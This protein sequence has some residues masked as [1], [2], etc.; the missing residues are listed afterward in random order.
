MPLPVHE[1]SPTTALSIVTLGALLLL[2]AFEAATGRYRD[3]RK[4]VTDWQMFGLST[5][6]IVLLERPLLYYLTYRLVEALGPLPALPAVRAWAAEHL[7]LSVVA[8]IAIDELVHGYAHNFAHKPI[9]KHRLLA[10]LHAFYREAHRGHHLV[11]GPDGKGEVSVTQ[12]IVAGW[13]WMLFLPNYWF[14][15]L[16]LALG[17]PE[18]WLWGMVLKNLWGMHVHTNWR[19]DLYLLNHPN[20]LV[21]GTM[22]AL[23]HVLT[24]PNQ[25]HQHHA[26]SRNSARD[27]QNVL[28]LYDWLLWGTLV[29]E[30]SRPKVYGWQ[31]SARDRHALYRYFNRRLRTRK[32]RG[33]RAATGY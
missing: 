33:V 25:H 21:R 20:R 7:S 18:T 4:T 6:G 23:C 19:Y 1:I 22:W 2:V 29:I 32:R 5:A 16:L 17:M 30:R 14:S 8:F 10:K 24:F 27:M 9:P 3:G 28:A 11:G 26:R 31:Q 12:A 15:A 13:G